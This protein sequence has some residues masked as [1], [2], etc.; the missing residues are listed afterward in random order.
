LKILEGTIANIPPQ[1]GRKHPHQE[2]IPMNTA[3]IL[4]ICGGAFVGLER[5]VEARMKEKKI[6]FGA[7]E[8]N[9]TKL[10]ENPLIDVQPH[11]LM[12]FGMI[13]ELVGRIPIICALDELNVE[14]LV[15]IL[16]VPK[17]SLLK[18]YQ[19]LLRLDGVDLRFTDGALKQIAIEA[20][21]KKTGARGLRAI[22]EKL[23]T[24]VMFECPDRKDIKKLTVDKDMVIKN[25]TNDIY[26][27][28]QLI[29]DKP[30]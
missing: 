29:Q 14:D 20:M 11:D 24:K 6:G 1:G 4:F 17:N 16:T 18:Q 12:K 5:I 30:A 19:H 22:M 3:N 26:V 27:D 9:Q 2:F 10:Q 13:P 25:Q 21:E 28:N 23:M 15:R 8:A 7:F